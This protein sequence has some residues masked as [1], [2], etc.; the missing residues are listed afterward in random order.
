MD[1]EIRQWL[2]KMTVEEKAS[3]CSGSGFWNLKGLKRLDIPSIMVSDGPHGL[4]K[5]IQEEDGGM[6]DSE[7]ATCF[8]TASALASTWDVDL[9]EKVGEAIGKEAKSKHVSVLLGPGANIKRH[10]YCGRNFEYFSEDP[11]LSGKMAAAFIRGVQSEGVG[12]A[13][14]H[15]VA[16]NQETN[17]F[18][19]DAIIDER[20]LREI[21]LRS[22]EIA[23]KEG[24]PWSVMTAYNKVNGTY[25]S[26][27]GNL[28]NDV[29][30]GEWGFN[31][32]T[33]TDWGG[34]NDRVTGL[35]NGQDLQMPGTNGDTDKEIVR[36]V[37]EGDIA[38]EVLDETTER[39]LSLIRKG[40]H[41]LDAHATY[42]EHQH[43]AFARHASAEGMVLLK[44]EDSILPLSVDD[45]IALIGDFARHPRYQGSGSSQINPTML[46]NTLD[47]FLEKAGQKVRYARGFDLETDDVNETFIESALET[48]QTTDKVVVM[49][50]LPER[51][52]SEGFDREHLRLPI[53]QLALIERLLTVTN[54][55]VVT[56]SNGAP[57]E[58]PFNDFVPAILETYLSGQ[59]GGGAVVD[60]LYGDHVPSGKLAE[61]FPKTASD[62]P[63]DRYFPGQRRQIEYREGPYVGYRFFETAGVT[64]L[65]PF[66][67]G[68]S[69]TDF[70]IETIT[71]D[72]EALDE[73]DTLIIRT[74][75]TNIGNRTG[76][77]TL[78]LYMGMPESKVSRPAKELTAFRKVTLEAGESTDVTFTIP[79]SD[80]GY[81]DITLNRFAVETGIYDCMV[82]TSSRDIHVQKSFQVR[83][84]EPVGE[85]SVYKQPGSDFALSR[86]DF[87]KRLGHPVPEPPAVKPYHFNSTLGELSHTLIGKILRRQVN[88]R[89][90]ALIGDNAS[91]KRMV[92]AMVDSM[93]LRAL[94]MMSGGA[95]GKKKAKGL[96]HL[97][98]RRYLKG[99]R[100]LLSKTS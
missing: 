24:K 91:N 57:V 2:S 87:E 3:L 37:R 70:K 20:T 66:G 38:G 75:I 62:M 74:R 52:E 44:N 26:E 8:P 47:A 96:V 31:G 42:D 63:A 98:N 81:F 77:E 22:F 82:G 93:P 45:E 34:C 36:A 68:L 18:V 40:R 49:L 86:E 76:K 58:L 61:S 43:H 19:T 80:L 27:Q 7:K 21:Y 46:D 33:I 12:T 15:Y 79:Y 28:V 69:Y 53:N 41:V 78:Q 54:K 84:H 6:L 10:P 30:R 92:A 35:L 50:G 14:K 83:G 17:R 100:A 25:M 64:P 90:Q 94:H 65:Y 51:A 60:V 73:G 99:L 1:K 55:L 9:I 48:A 88:K 32:L 89:M 4:R 13:L 23:V 85:A 11:L 72:P 95:L 16:N 59:A 5:S 67:H 71:C 39:V 56:L 97:A 29:L